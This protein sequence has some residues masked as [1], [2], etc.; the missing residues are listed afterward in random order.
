[1]EGGQREVDLGQCGRERVGMEGG[2]REVDLGQ[3]ER[4]NLGMDA[5]RGR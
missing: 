4:E 2:Q 1:M 5:E 3:C